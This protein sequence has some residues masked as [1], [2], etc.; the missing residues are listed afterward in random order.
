MDHQ[1]PMH[2]SILMDD[3][4]R[5]LPEEKSNKI[6]FNGLS[7]EEVM[8]YAEDPK[9]VRL[10]WATFVL[11]WLVW[12]GM[13]VSACLIVYLTPK[14]AYVPKQPW[15][16]KELVYEVNV[17]NF[18]DSDGNGVG[19]LKGLNSK[20]DYLK[21]DL[22]VRALLLNSDIL[23]K[24]KVNIID[25]KYETNDFKM[26][27]FQKSLKSNDMHL[28]I[29]ISSEAAGKNEASVSEWLNNADGVRI[30]GVEDAAS[31][32]LLNKYLGLVKESEEKTF[33]KKFFSV[34]PSTN[35]GFKASNS[36]TAFYNIAFEQGFQFEKIRSFCNDTK[37]GVWPSI[38]IDFSKS[39]LPEEHVKIVHGISLLLRGTPF[40]DYGDEIYLKSQAEK[41]Y[42]KWDSTHSCGFTTDKTVSLNNDCNNTVAEELSH[43]AG[44]TLI[45][46]YK[47]LNNLRAKNSFLFGEIKLPSS[48][49]KDTGVFVSEAD[50]FEGFI[51]A[52]NYGASK[53]SFN[54]RDLF[55]EIVELP[56]KAKVEY[57]DWYHPRKNSD[58]D[59][60]KEV[61]TEAILLYPAE[62]LVLS[63]TN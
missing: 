19:D 21:N 57:F 5:F 8:R 48:D 7:K 13:L 40:L 1:E 2:A 23:A 22:G 55:S 36:S 15:W 60:N 38:K 4:H 58:F 63:Y 25:S 35:A 51:V 16:E 10:R 56:A 37:S 11:F 9:W 44:N 24:D 47:S 61:S 3:T 27:D 34:Y 20:L 62:F 12:F 32:S 33:E 41:R 50:R 54:F 59:T 39:S 49:L 17:G 14:C 29:D 18:K 31:F 42:M 26:N 30:N 45:R 6:Q 53:K 28:I 46:M 43:G 52:T